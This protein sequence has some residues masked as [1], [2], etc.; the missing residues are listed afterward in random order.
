[1]ESI[2]VDRSIPL[3]S[4]FKTNDSDEMSQ[5]IKGWDQE[6][7]Q[8]EKGQFSWEI[9][10]IQIG[11]F[12][13]YE[14]S[15]GAKTYAKG[16]V[17]AETIVVAVF[18]QSL[19]CEGRFLGVELTPYST[20]VGNYQQQYEFISGNQYKVLL[21]AAP[22]VEV[23]S[24][25]ERMQI[26][27]TEKQLLSQRIIIPN[28]NVYNEFSRYLKEVL[29]MGKMQP[30]LLKDPIK[31]KFWGQLILA[32]AI[33]LFIDILNAKPLMFLQEKHSKRRQMVKQ[34]ER[35]MKENLQQ[36]I[37]L[38]DLCQ[39][40]NLSQRSVY[41]AFQEAYGL[42]PMQYLKILRLNSVRRSLKTSNPVNTTVTEIATKWGFWHLGQFSVDYRKMFGEAPAT[43][44]RQNPKNV[45]GIV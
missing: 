25:A 37:T 15:F 1:M 20:V 8:L 28:S 39:E 2:S 14:E 21:M 34:A 26:P 24:F 35:L 38:K 4:H 29:V 32:D 40:I 9:D 22:I 12:Q 11:K 44:L 41:Y 30:A 13:I 27:L 5:F 45:V 7:I 16:L 6:Y 33:P 43:T 36:P 42:P 17:P 3:I 31:S 19:S 23:V 18:P 10:I